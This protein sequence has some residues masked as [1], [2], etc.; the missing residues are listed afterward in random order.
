MQFLQAV[1]A[2]LTLAAL[3]VR[4]AVAAG[5]APPMTAPAGLSFLELKVTGE[6]FILLQNNST[7]NITDL[8][9]Y[10][11]TAYN[12]VNPLAQGVASSSQ[13]LP[14][15]SLQAGQTM[16]LSA[17]AMQ[18]CGASVAGKLSISLSDSG[19]FLQLVQTGINQ[20]GAVTQTPGD[21]VNWSSVV[22][23]LIQNLPSSTKEPRS[24]YYRYLNGS[25]Y[26]WQQA[27]IDVSNTCQLNIV[28]AGGL[29][30]SSAV[31]PLTLAATSPP[32]TILGIGATEI[33][34]SQA[35]LPAADVGLQAPQISELLANPIGSGNDSSD[36]Y[37]ELYNPNDKP[38]ELTGFSLQTGLTAN[39]AYIFPANTTL[40]PH[41]FR[42]FYS[43]ATKLSL[44]NTSGQAVLLDPFGALLSR[45]D[46]YGTAKDGLSWAL[47]NG[48]WFWTTESTPGVANVIKQPVTKKAAA[49]KSK[50]TT[51]SKFG[52]VKGSKTSQS[53]QKV[54]SGG[55]PVDAAGSPVHGWVLALIASGALLYGAYEYRRDIANR[56]YQLGTKLSPRRTP[57]PVPK[58]GRSD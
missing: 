25:S 52:A 8:S 13:Q 6:E 2:A 4:P 19:G 24:A 49:S 3:A 47:A 23:G 50:K 12:N 18:T 37:I 14:L 55:F 40:E 5:I 17:S 45:T 29:G 9:S 31:T 44:S 35:S 54:S 34:T 57:R 21:L 41:A 28:V 10:W 56:L 46:V 20:N 39:H 36:E 32:A 42:A 15:A 1:L 38:F 48:T 27:T 30:S 43:S 16:L 53:A 22:T 11:L 51:S 26:A 33:T 7:T 58:G